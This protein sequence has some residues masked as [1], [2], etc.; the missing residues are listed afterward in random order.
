MP[1]ILREYNEFDQFLE[2]AMR[3][4]SE[5]I[6]K[7]VEGDNCNY[8]AIGTD[9]RFG[10]VEMRYSIERPSLGGGYHY[11]N[12]W[13]IDGKGNSIFLTE[14]KPDLVEMLQRL[15]A[16]G[17]DLLTLKK[18][19]ASKMRKLCETEEAEGNET[20]TSRFEETTEKTAEFSVKTPKWGTIDVRIRMADNFGT[21]SFRYEMIIPAPPKGDIKTC[22]EMVAEAKMRLCKGRASVIDHSTMR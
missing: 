2:D 22:D 20:K 10:L 3:S 8:S 18:V 1:H 21:A 15:G 6:F 12:R 4:E 11:G 5:V 13:K 19:Q 7:N 17:A 14:K 16:D 9:P